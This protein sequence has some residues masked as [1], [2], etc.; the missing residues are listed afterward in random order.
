MTGK[1]YLDEREEQLAARAGTVSFYVMF[2]TAVLV[3]IGELLYS[4]NLRDTAGETVILLAGG[5]TCLAV[6]IKNGIWTGGRRFRWQQNFL[7]SIACSGIF[8]VL[9]GFAIAQKASPGTDIAK[10]VLSFF[11]GIAVLCF[12][13]VT[14]L[15]SAAERKRKKQEKRYQQE[16]EGGMVQEVRL[17]SVGD[18]IQA[19]M[20]LEILCKNGIPAY[21]QGGV[22]DIYA[23]NSIDGEEIYVRGA[24][25]QKAQ[26]I[27]SELEEN[28]GNR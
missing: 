25:F 7:G 23:G 28:G 3:I 8:S 18:R 21:R 19:E 11:G 12:L 9:Y 4:G 26:E 17:C 14:L 27:L 16:A 1:N 2:L 22:M 6:N 24:D 5:V 15:G 20:L 13:S 10:Y